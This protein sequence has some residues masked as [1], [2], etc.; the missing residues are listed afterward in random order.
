MGKLSECQAPLGGFL[1]EGPIPNVA[2][3]HLHLVIATPETQA[4]VV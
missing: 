4:H 3:G 1:G 2:Q